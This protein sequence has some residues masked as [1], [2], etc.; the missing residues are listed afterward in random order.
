[1]RMYW[2]ASSSAMPADATGCGC[3][4]PRAPS[5]QASGTART[6]TG[7][8]GGPA[9]RSCP[10]APG[11]GGQ[12]PAPGGEAEGSGGA[13]AGGAARGGNVG[14]GGEP[15]VDARYAQRLQGRKGDLGGALLEA[16][17][18][19]RRHEVEI[20]RSSSIEELV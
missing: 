6:V 7:R 1:M 14:S 12:G 16:L 9:R 10:A 3:P 19:V 18:A 15:A 20:A 5:P 17:L 2:R 11:R 4:S 8:S 13:G